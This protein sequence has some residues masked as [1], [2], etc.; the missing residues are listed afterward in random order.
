MQEIRS[1]IQ[2]IYKLLNHIVQFSCSVLSDSSWPHGLQHSRLPSPTPTPRACSTHVCQVSDA[3]QPSRPLSSPSPAI[4]NLSQHQGIFQW[5]SA[6]H[7]VAK[8]LELQH[9][10]YSGLISFMIDRFD[11]LAVEG[12]LESLLQH[13]SSKHQ[14]FDD[15]HTRLLE[16][17][18][19]D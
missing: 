17:H 5:V 3:I 7:Q 18:S 12:T 2:T 11:V 14:F 8:V 9:Q 1:A 13:H 16:N 4:F 15:I 6:S 10:Y 19:L